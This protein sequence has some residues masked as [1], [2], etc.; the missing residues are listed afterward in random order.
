M[1]KVEIVMKRNPVFPRS[2][3]YLMAVAEQRSF[4]R[5]AEV[6]YVSQPTLSQQ[7]RQLEDLLETQLLD[8]SGR[9]VRLTAAGEVYLQYAHRALGELEAGKRAIYDLEDLSRG[10]LRLGMMPVTDYLTTPLLHEFIARY[11]GINLSTT[12]M[13]Q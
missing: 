4:T 13:S 9:S 3:H 12:E 6:L 7:I 8:R 2:I 1:A 5:A 11:P 10:S